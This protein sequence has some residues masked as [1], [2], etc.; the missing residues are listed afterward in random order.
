METLFDP[1]KIVG[2]SEE[3]AAIMLKKEGYNELPSQ[4]KQSL[5]FILLDILKEPIL[6]LL[7]GADMIYLFL[8]EVTD[9]LILLMFVFVVIGITFNQERKTERALDVLKSLSSPRALVTRDGKQKKNQVG[10]S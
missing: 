1:E 9:A 3:E 8:G 4:K 10:K 6:L 5:L 2:L 7:L